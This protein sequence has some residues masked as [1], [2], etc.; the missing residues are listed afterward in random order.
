MSL[1]AIDVR[2]EAPIP[3]KSAIGVEVPNA[4]PMTVSLRECLD[5]D[6]YRNAPPS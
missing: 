3:G 1:A 5:T 2:V 4:T 6:E